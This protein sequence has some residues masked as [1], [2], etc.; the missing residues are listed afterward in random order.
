M[1]MHVAVVGGGLTG[2]V[3]ARS[4]RARDIAVTLI[5]RGGLLGGRLRMVDPIV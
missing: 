5:D 4:L 3:A 2:L 1:P